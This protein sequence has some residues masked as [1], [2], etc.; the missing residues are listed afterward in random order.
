V[1]Q[2]AQQ[3]Y[4][5]SAVQTATPAQ[6]VVMLYD[7][8]IRFVKLGV[9]GIEQKNYQ[10]ANHNLVKAQA[11]LHELTGALNHDFPISKQLVQ[12]YE[13]MLYQLIQANLKKTTS[14]AQEV[15]QHLNILRDAWAQAAKSVGA[16]QRLSHV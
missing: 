14:P 8:A 2:N 7:G 9:E 12:I 1:I 5:Y 16:S 6:L 15:L 10:K 11:I 13:Y 4:Q 3:K